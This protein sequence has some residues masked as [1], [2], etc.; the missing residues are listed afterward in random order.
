[1]V[2]LKTKSGKTIR[3]APKVKRG[4]RAYTVKKSN[5]S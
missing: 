3:I 2:V 4:K 1:M 5:K